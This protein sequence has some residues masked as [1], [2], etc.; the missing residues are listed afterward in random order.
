MVHV[1]IV[2]LLEDL[3]L[4]LLLVQRLREARWWLNL[5]WSRCRSWDILGN[6]FGSRSGG[7]LGNR[8]GSGHRRRDVGGDEGL[9]N[10]W[11]VHRRSRHDLAWRN[12]RWRERL[13]RLRSLV[14]GWSEGRYVR[15][16]R[17]KGVVHHRNGFRSS[18]RELGWSGSWSRLERLWDRLRGEGWC[19][20]GLRSEGRLRSN[21]GGL[22]LRSNEGWL[23][24][25]SNEGGLRFRSSESRLWLR[26]NEGRLRLRSSKGRL[27]LRSNE[28]RLRW[29]H[30]CRSLNRSRSRLNGRLVRLVRLVLHALRVLLLGHL[31]RLEL[32]S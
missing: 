11:E 2:L 32:V 7:K 12:G 28:G 17:S 5:Y 4:R 10:R 23:R 20:F 22:W 9:R 15:G 29:I 8:F 1:L 13:E 6:R 18:G 27:W 19:G 16:S 14:V 3:F 25:R 30:R 31:G 26:S 24:F 21:K